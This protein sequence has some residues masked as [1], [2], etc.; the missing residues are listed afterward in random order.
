MAVILRDASIVID[1]VDL[2][3][4]ANQVE[5]TSSKDVHE[6]TGFGAVNKVKAL[7]LGDGTMNFNF[8]QSFDAA[9]VD[10]TLW[11]IHSANEEVV[12]VVK[13]DAGAV[14]ATNPSYTMTGI[15]PEYTPLSGG[16]GEPS[17]IDITFE[18]ASQDGIVR[19]IGV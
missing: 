19:G 4:F 13:G 5:V 18:N 10:A 17:E 1:G 14:S 8:F 6:V 2:S 16:V 3:A 12:I 9:E 15:L 7:G 11:P